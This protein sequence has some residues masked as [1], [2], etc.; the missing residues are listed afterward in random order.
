MTSDARIY[1][2]DG[3]EF[4]IDEIGD[5][6][7][8]AVASGPD[9]VIFYVHG[10]GC[11]GG[12][13]PQKS[14][15]GSMPEME[16]DYAAKAIMFNWQGS[17]VGC[18]LGFPEDEAR[19]AGPAFAHALKKLAY[20]LASVPGLAGGA[21]LT[22]ITHSMGSLVLEE[23]ASDPALPA[24]LF[25]TVVVGS[26]ASARDGHQPWLSEVALSPALYVT[27]NDDDNV[28]TAASTLGGTR[29]GKNVDG[30][31][32]A[33]NAVYVD[34]TASSVNHAYYVVSGQEGAHMMAFFA[35]VM[36]GVPYDLASPVG[37]ASVETRDGTAIYHFD[38]D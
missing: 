32:L 19:A 1:T 10:R 11:G 34:F 20:E 3:S 23:A 30:A 4:V 18:P 25:D 27:L 17:D 15:E 33:A 5:A 38:G 21:R 29:L 14:L 26:A 12:G 8:H 16:S 28:L 37:I 36:D 24:A 6:L 31:A 35:D 9:N 2:T 13:E 22:L 7:A